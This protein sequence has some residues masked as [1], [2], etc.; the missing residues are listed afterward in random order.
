[1]S[2]EV[3]QLVETLMNLAAGYG[4]S[5]LGAIVILIVGLWLSGRISRMIRRLMGRSG[6]V[7]PTLVGFVAS[8][9][10]YAIVIFTVVAVLEKFG[11]QT[12]SLIAVLGAAGLALGLALQGTLSNFAAG[13]MLLLFRPFKAGQYVDAGG[14]AG[15]VREITLFFTEMDTPDN[16]RITVPNGQVWGQ[17]IRNFSHNETRRLDIGCGISYADDISKAMAVLEKL[18]KAEPRVMEDPAP[19][20][21]V[22]ALADSSVNLVLRVWCAAGDYWQLKWDTT[23]AVKDAFDAEGIEIPF[24]QRT[25]HLLREAAA[26][27]SKTGEGPGGS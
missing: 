16:V 25:V 3:S 12:T 9:V 24:P 11:V 1:M 10:K 2:N 26:E 13:V 17:A 21:F 7:D 14:T 22:D 4:L 23:K 20:T 8:L 15:T 5:V 18:A 27:K 6:K 19:T